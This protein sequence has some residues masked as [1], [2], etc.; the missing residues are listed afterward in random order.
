MQYDT[1]YSVI[2]FDTWFVILFDMYSTFILTKIMCVDWVAIKIGIKF[3]P[4]KFGLYLDRIYTNLAPLL[5]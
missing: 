2:L 4:P 1:L 3:I 5:V